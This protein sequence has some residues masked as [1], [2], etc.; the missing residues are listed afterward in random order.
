MTGLVPSGI[1]PS[2][3]QWGG[4]YHWIV[5]IVYRI[6]EVQRLP[7]VFITLAAWSLSEVVRYPQYALNALEICPQWLTWLRYTAFILLYPLGALPGEVLLL[8]KALPYIKEKN[9]YGCI[10]EKLPFT[11]YS[12][13]VVI[14]SLYPFLWFGLYLYM[15]KQRRYKLDKQFIGRRKSRGKKSD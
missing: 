11:Y 14:L 8:Y 12:V 5:A 1:L 10:F 13:V 3:L 9:L 4:R 6:K 7:S 15:F 2:L